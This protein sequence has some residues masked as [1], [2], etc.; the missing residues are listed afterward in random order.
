[1]THSSLR[2]ISFT[3]NVLKSLKIIAY[4]GKNWYKKNM[5]NSALSYN[6]KPSITQFLVKYSGKI[7]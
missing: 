6:L 5:T 7:H 1:M 3:K 4:D 2:T